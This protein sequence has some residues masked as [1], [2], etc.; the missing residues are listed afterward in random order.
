MHLSEVARLRQQI[1]LELEAMQRGLTGI[2]AGTARHDFIHA[3]M[4]RIGSCQ[5]KLAEHVGTTTATTM[6]CQL[7]VQVIDPDLARES[8]P[9]PVT[10]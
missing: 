1:E 2:A 9:Q 5:D 7:Y 6:V 4:Q 10:T 3:K 8:V